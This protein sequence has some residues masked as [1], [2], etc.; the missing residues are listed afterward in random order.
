MTPEYTEI[1]SVR[2]KA[3]SRTLYVDLKE[4]PDGSRFLSISEVKHGADVR[5]RILIDEQYVPDLFR[6]LGAVLD[7]IAPKRA[8]KLYTLEEKRR[9]HPRA[10]EAWTEEEDQRLKAGFA[11]ELNVDQLAQRHGRAP[12]AIKHRL[13][14]LGLSPKRS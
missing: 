10:Y 8:A 7:F 9:T 1:I 2:V 12:S 4:T 6:A 14:R 3:G 5:S 11:Q 13:E